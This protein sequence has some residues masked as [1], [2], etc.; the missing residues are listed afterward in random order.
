[1]NAIIK[2]LGRLIMGC[3]LS[4]CFILNSHAQLPPGLT[5]CPTCPPVTNYVSSIPAPYVPGLKLTINVPNTTNLSLGFLEADPAAKYDIYYTTDLTAAAWSDVL[6]GTNGQTNF[7]RVLSQHGNGFFKA[8][9][10]DTPITSAANLTVSF[11]NNLVNSN[12]ITATVSGGPAAAMAYLVNNTNFA[13]ARWFPFSAVPWVFLGTN[14]GTYSIWFGFRGSDGTN[15]WSMTT[16]TLDTTPPFLVIT[17]PTANA[18]SKPMIQLQGYSIEQLASLIF[19]VTNSQGANASGEGLVTDQCFDP[20][21]SKFTTNWFECL[22]IGLTLGTNYVSLQATD[23]AGNVTATNLIYVF[24]TN[25]DST[26]PAMTLFWPQDGTQI[27]GTDFSVR[28]ILD[29]ET[30]NL[31]AQIISTNGITNIVSGLVERDGKFW[32]ESLPL[33]QGTNLLLLTA[34][35]SAGNTSATNISVFQ[36]AHTMTIDEPTSD[37]LW[38]QTLTVTGTIDDVSDYTVWVNGQKAAFTGGNA[39]TATNV[40]LPQGGTAVIQARAIPNSD[41]GGNGTGGSGGGPVTYDNLGNPDPPQN[42]DLEFQTNRTEHIYVQTYNSGYI[43]YVTNYATLYLT[44]SFQTN[45]M[46]WTNGIGGS[47]NYHNTLAMGSGNYQYLDRHILWP[48][49]VWQPTLNGTETDIYSGGTPSTNVVSVGPPSFNWEES[50]SMNIGNFYN[51]SDHSNLTAIFNLSTRTVVRYFTGGKSLPLR[52]SL[53]QLS[54]TVTPETLTW[55]FTPGAGGGP[56]TY[57][58]YGTTILSGFTAGTFGAMGSDGNNYKALAD[59]QSVDVTPQVSGINNYIF[60]MTPT[61]YRPFIQANN[62]VYSPWLQPDHVVPS[63]TNFWVGQKITFSINWLPSTPP[64]VSGSSFFRWHFPGDYVNEPMIYWNGSVPCTNYN[65]NIGLFANQTAYCWYKRGFSAATMSIGMN[66]LFPNGQIVNIAN[67]GMFSVKTPTFAANNL[68]QDL[69]SS[70]TVTITNPSLYVTN[71]SSNVTLGNA[72]GGYARFWF[73]YFARPGDNFFETQIVQ[74]YR[75]YGNGSPIDSGTN[76]WFDGTFVKPGS[77]S[78]ADSAGVAIVQQT[79]K[80]P[81]VPLSQPEAKVNDVFKTYIRYQPVEAGSI[82]ITLQRVDWSW[83]V[84]AHYTNGLWNIPAG[85]ISTP[86]NHDDDA[87]PLWSGTH[88]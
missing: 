9:R 57:W 39:W 21:L 20:N 70:S 33:A 28:G 18:I 16:I 25:G 65:V 80:Y 29:D 76:W 68:S 63:A 55:G 71:D 19:A 74:S 49:D 62:S 77:I 87:F 88:P 85:T 44:P 82:S 58:N 61:K 34:T 53:H 48:A 38:N 46:R 83:A 14:D 30:A 26:P 2:I 12:F 17:N 51:S 50:G 3:L 40:Y 86:A 13:S 54:A 42:F 27:S 47:K 52:Y 78:P 23:L 15:Y 7:F 24:S 81:G 45:S 31:T 84:D 36:G 37:D 59:G 43:F 75:K 8:A 35:D 41:N 79:D 64:Y 67:L 73:S 11:P 66:L 5:N 72:Q 22:D 56:W 32:V 69:D 10:T 6:Q 60:T 1:M 4:C